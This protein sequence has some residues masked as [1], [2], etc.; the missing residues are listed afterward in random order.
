[1]Q[2]GR[3]LIL[4]GRIWSRFTV[5]LGQTCPLTLEDSFF[6]I[7]EVK[8]D[9]ISVVIFIISLSLVNSD[10]EAFI[11]AHGLWIWQLEIGKQSFSILND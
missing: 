5:H 8:S 10:G 2:D 11:S 6:D 7:Y 9:H 4:N 3:Q 1:V